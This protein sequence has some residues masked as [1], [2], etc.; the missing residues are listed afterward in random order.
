MV[1]GMSDLTD[2]LSLK[3]A[4]YVGSS[5]G[6]QGPTGPQGETGPQGATGPTGLAGATNISWRGQYSNITPYA[7]NDAVGYNGS[8]YYCVQ[9]NTG[10]HLPTDTNYWQP[11]SMLGATGPQGPAGPQGPTGAQGSIGATGPKGDAGSG[12]VKP[13]NYIYVGKN[14]NDTTGDGSAGSPYLTISKAITVATSGTTI[15]IFPGTYA[16][17]I[18]FKTGVN[19]TCGVQYGVYIT[20]NHVAS[21]TGTVI[22]ENIVFQNASSSASG[23]T[24]AIGG[25]TALN[26]QLLNCFV[27]SQSTSGAGDAI[28]WTNTNASSKLQFVDGNSSVTASNATARC[29]YATTG[30]AGSVVANR[31]SFKLDNP[32]NIALAIGGAITFTHTSDAVT[33]QVVVANTAVYVGSLIALTTTSVA[34]FT[35]T[36]SGVSVLSSVPITTT[37]SPAVA[38]TGGLAFVAIEYLST[39]V[40]GASTLNGGLGASPLTMAPIRIRSS[41]LLPSG[42]VAAG[43]LSG[44]FEFDGTHLYFTIGTTRS[45]VI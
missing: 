5:T 12:V 15:F 40:G 28:V 45:V 2:I 19:L 25:T 10:G 41:A 14:G 38:G 34:A 36:S 7:S 35:T 4:R 32:N 26:L 22:C 43:A 8:T 42:A 11:L 29:F 30:A 44:T 16:E 1:A 24:L 9:A 23:T 18:T 21:F 6:P 31:V 33:G 27:N 3:A 37:A 17:N 20:G 13:T 39:G